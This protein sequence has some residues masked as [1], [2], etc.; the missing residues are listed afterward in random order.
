MRTDQVGLSSLL[1][2]RGMTVTT[3]ADST[4][5]PVLRGRPISTELEKR[6]IKLHRKGLGFTA[7]CM[8]LEADRTARGPTSV[9]QVDALRRETSNRRWQGGQSSRKSSTSRR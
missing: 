6:M 9:S 1:E 4:A 7:I 2:G 5:T 8:Q 3:T